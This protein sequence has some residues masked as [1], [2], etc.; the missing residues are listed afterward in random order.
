MPRF[1]LVQFCETVQ[2]EKITFTALV[3]PIILLLAKNP[4][5]DQYDLSSIK[6]VICGAAPLGVDLSQQVKKRIPTMIVKQGYGLTETSPC[7]IVEPTD[8]VIDGTL[9]TAHVSIMDTD[10]FIVGST[11]LLLSNMTAK[12]VD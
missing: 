12:I 9:C 6:L 2:K 8:R 7:A 4:L 10:T 11:G 1:D 5:I 3:P